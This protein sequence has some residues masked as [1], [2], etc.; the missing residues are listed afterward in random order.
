MLPDIATLNARLARAETT[1]EALIDDVLARSRD[2]RAAHVFTQRY[3]A[4][5]REQA[6]HADALQR[7][8]APLSPLAGLPLSVKDLYDVAGQAT[9]AGAAL[10]RDDAQ[11]QPATEDAAAVKRL[12]DTGAALVGKTNMTE[13]AF[14]GVG[15]NPH[16][17]TPANPA[18]A[19]TARIPG[20]SSSGAAVS[21]ALGLSVAA[22]GS[23]TG[24]SIRVPAALCGIVGF[25]SSQSRVPLAGAFPLS[26]TLD[27]ACAMTRCVA[28][29]LL[30]DAV[31]GGRPLPVA[32]RPLAGRRLLLPQTLMLDTLDDSVSRALQAALSALSAAGAMIVEAPWPAL[33]D[34]ARLNSPGGFSAA[35]A[36]AVHRQDMLSR[37]GRFDP[38]VAARV[39]L[40]EAV[41]AADYQQLHRSRQAWIAQ[42]REQLEPFD[43]LLCPT[44]PLV[45]PPIAELQASDEA[46]FRANGLLL[47][48]T[49]AINYLDGCAFS[50]PC[51]P[52]GSLPVGLMLAAAGGQDATLA[53]VALAAEGA[54]RAAGLGLPANA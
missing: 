1:R 23:D 8:G 32:R 45:A 38:R 53:S 10:R 43:A 21:V 2:T 22:L 19:Q 47:R 48:N 9:W 36:W 44:V 50:L 30:V 31:L 14:S 28:D 20:G 3:E 49:F 7:L 33:A 26:H 15:I 51:H 6:R 52:P 42:A 18:D 17:G 46:F 5:A 41:S 27:T 39:A 54:L 35:E 12:R 11:L 40:G 13:F 29:A 34:I 37:R 4:L 16:F 24:G 25:K